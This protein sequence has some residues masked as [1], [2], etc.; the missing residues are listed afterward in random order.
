MEQKE[1]SRYEG[2][3]SS[4]RSSTGERKMPGGCHGKLRGWPWA[5]GRHSLM[6]EKRSRRRRGRRRRRTVR[7]SWTSKGVEMGIAMVSQR[8]KEAR[9]WK[10]FESNREKRD[11]CWKA[12]IKREPLNDRPPVKIR[13]SFFSI[14]STLGA[15]QLIPGGS[16]I[17]CNCFPQFWVLASSREIITLHVICETMKKKWLRFKLRVSDLFD[18]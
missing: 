11:R 4:S 14:I 10:R 17:T 9:G 8:S 12:R 3:G 16:T 13:I 2:E 15:H 1:E 6:S 5:P 7:R 18:S